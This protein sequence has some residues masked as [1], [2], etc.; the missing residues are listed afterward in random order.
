MTLSI[1]NINY[2]ILHRFSQK[3]VR[4]FNFAN[5]KRE[6]KEY[7]V[8]VWKTMIYYIFNGISHQESKIGKSNPKNP[9]RTH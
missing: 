5:D 8:Y 4:A 6:T 9:G 1:I 7:I 2:I 3:N